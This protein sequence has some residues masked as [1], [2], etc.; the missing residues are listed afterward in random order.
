MPTRTEFEIGD[1][2]RWIDPLMDLFDSSR[3]EA[4]MKVY[5]IVIG[6]NKEHPKV[7]WFDK[8]DMNS[9]FMESDQIVLVSKANKRIKP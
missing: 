2:V 4:Y 5:G 1:L 7:F 9:Y 6:F 8:V 3:E